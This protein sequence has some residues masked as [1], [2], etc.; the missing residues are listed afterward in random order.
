MQYGPIS[1][2]GGTSNGKP[3]FTGTDVPVQTF[4]EYMEAGR[5]PERFLED[6]P[7]INRKDV[8]EVLQMAKAVVTSEKVLKDNFPSDE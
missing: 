7:A 4:F 5:S 6:Y 1:F 8:N 3:V 2:E